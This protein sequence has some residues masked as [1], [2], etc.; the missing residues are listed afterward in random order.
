MPN[1]VERIDLRRVLEYLACE[2]EIN[3]VLVEA[4]AVLNGSLLTEHLVDEIVLYMAPVI[5]G[6]DARGLFE[7]PTLQQ[8]SQRV[9]LELEDVRAVGQDWR[10]TAR[11]VYQAME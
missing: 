11:P 2:H 6:S 9:P 8:M 4:G 5:M 7:L 10:L 3:E 1:A